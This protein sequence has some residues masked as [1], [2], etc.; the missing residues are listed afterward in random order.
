MEPVSVYKN[1]ELPPPARTVLLA[2][3]RVFQGR[4]QTS[5]HALEAPSPTDLLIG[6]ER[7][8]Q[9]EGPSS[10]AECG[11]PIPAQE[12][13]SRPPYYIQLERGVLTFVA[14]RHVSHPH[15]RYPFAGVR[16]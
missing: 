3:L 5:L 1:E 12:S 16:V 8:V 2:F 6:L 15:R 14:Y 4:R 11:Q 10:L 13:R 9:C 7:L